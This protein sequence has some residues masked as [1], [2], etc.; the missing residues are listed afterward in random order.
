MPDEI[1]R[2]RNAFRRRGKRIP[3]L[4][5]F[6]GFLLLAVVYRLYFWI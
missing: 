6:L 5:I 1:V 2:L 4:V 3:A